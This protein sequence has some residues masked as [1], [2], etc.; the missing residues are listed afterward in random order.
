VSGRDRGVLVV[1]LFYRPEPNFIT[2]DVAEAA[3]RGGRVTVITAHPNYPLG[4]FYPGT[5]WWRPERR[6]ENGVVVWRVPMFPDHSASP[7]RRAVSYL[8][9][10]LA[11]TLLAPF[12]AGRPRVVW[13]YQTPFTVAVAALWFKV[14]CR[15]RLVYTSADL[16]PESFAAT[17]VTRPGPLMRLLYAT[18]RALNRVADV[19]VGSTTG[20]VETYAA[21]GV[22]PERMK[23]IRVWVDGSPR[24]GALPAPPSAPVADVPTV[25]YAGNLGPAQGLDVVVRGAAELKRRGVAV[26][27]DLYGSGGAEDE[28]RALAAEL[29]ADNVAFHGRVPPAQ[30]VAASAAAAAQLV[31]LRPSPLFDMTVPSKLPFAI[32]MGTPLLCGLRGESARVA[33]ESGG[34]YLFDPTDAASMADATERVL[35]LDP[36]GRAAAR[37]RLLAYYRASL[38]PERLVAEYME[39]LGVG[40]P[41]R[42]VAAP[43][44]AG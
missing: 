42:G 11:A 19:I 15:S 8:S 27:F 35:V 10:T 26:R 44:P 28:L 32:G 23:L 37:E 5:R 17:G 33:A 21:D 40:E 4:H 34:A 12:V 13:V 2:A 29:G 36:A 25:V 43:P 7:L 9:F 38:D 14:V 20:I 1:T 18:R 39:L 30:A 22:P 3:A 41:P 24:G 16:W 31:V 6:V